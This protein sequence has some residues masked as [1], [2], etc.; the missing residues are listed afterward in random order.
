MY[1]NV[2]MI[3]ELPHAQMNLNNMQAI[4]DTNLCYQYIWLHYIPSSL[5]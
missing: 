2:I 3:T 4:N 1:R 5:G